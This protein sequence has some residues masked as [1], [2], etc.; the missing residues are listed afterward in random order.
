MGVGNTALPI[1]RHDVTTVQQARL[2]LG[3]RLRELRRDAGLNGVRLAQLTG[4]DNSKVS[5]I[6]HGKQTPTEDDI[7]VWCAH[8]HATLHVPDLIASV[9]NIEAAWAEWRRIV[10]AGHARRQLEAIEQENRTGL[11]RAFEPLMVPGMLQTREYARAVLATCIGF[12]EGTDDLEAAL[13]ARLERQQVLREGIHRF[14]YLL[15]EQVL[16]TTVGNDSVMSGQLD[17]LLEVMGLSRL[18]LGIVPRTA[19]LI[20]TTHSFTMY[21]GR[22]TQVETISAELT[23]TQPRELYFYEKAF[24][25]L[26]KQAVVGAAARALIEAALEQRGSPSPS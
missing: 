6:E 22:L 20:Y 23:V 9:R 8:T 3:I 25:A 15:S 7:R 26:A 13:V 2:N 21:D 12:V 19:A 1:C 16:Y 24:A 11:V 17:R 4:W 5:R 18:V 10:G 14:H